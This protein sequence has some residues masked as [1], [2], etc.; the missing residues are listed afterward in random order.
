MFPAVRVVMLVSCLCDCCYCVG[1]SSVLVLALAI[2]LV[3]DLV[4]GPCCLPFSCSCFFVGVWSCSCS[5]YSV[6]CRFVLVRFVC[7]GRV[8]V[9]LL[10]IVLDLVLGLLLIHCPLCVLLLLFS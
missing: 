4:G 7:L 10:T 1:S 6:R 8:L 5:E 9:L 3:L 2:A